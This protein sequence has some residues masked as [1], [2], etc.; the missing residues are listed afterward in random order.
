MH[1]RS[2]VS[3]PFVHPT[4]Q[5]IVF[6]FSGGVRDGQAIRSD[7]P[8]LAA[9]IKALWTMTWNGTVGRRFDVTSQSGPAQQRYQIESK[10]VVGSEIH[11]TCQHVD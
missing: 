4:E 10:A 7:E 8:Q 6:Q 11:V 1:R 9:E 5:V 3:D 2:A